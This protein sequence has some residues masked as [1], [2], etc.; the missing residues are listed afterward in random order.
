MLVQLEY[1]SKLRPP[2]SVIF[3]FPVIIFVNWNDENQLYLKPLQKK[4]EKQYPVEVI[5]TERGER[6]DRTFKCLARRAIVVPFVL[7]T[8]VATR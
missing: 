1:H 8:Q 7:A 5:P 3:P 4:K 6:R 2:W